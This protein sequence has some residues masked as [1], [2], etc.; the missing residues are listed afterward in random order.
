MGSV[1]GVK[2]ASEA[3]FGALKTQLPVPGGLMSR[4]VM[5]ACCCLALGACNSSNTPD[6]TS[7]FTGRW[8]GQGDMQT[9]TLPLFSPNMSP[10]LFPSFA[11]AFGITSTELNV[12]QLEPL[13]LFNGTSLKMRVADDSSLSFESFP[14]VPTPVTCP[15]PST[16][17]DA[18]SVTTVESA[19]GT[20]SDGILAL[21]IHGK[22]T[23]CCLTEHFVVGLM[24]AKQ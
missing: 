6:R 11:G 18:T 20:L 21:S 22:H 15:A 2:S 12:V 17:T 5:A 1:T 16:C 7:T 19:S 9:A 13:P 8:L 14:A 24:A 23:Q 10:P 3:V 4:V